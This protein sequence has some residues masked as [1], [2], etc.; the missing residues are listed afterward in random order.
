MTT[1]TIVVNWKSENGQETIAVWKEPLKLLSRSG[2][3]N[4]ENSHQNKKR[5]LKLL[6]RHGEHTNAEKEG[7]CRKSQ[8]NYIIEDPKITSMFN[9]FDSH[10]VEGTRWHTLD[11]P[12]S[13]HSGATKLLT[14]IEKTFHKCYKTSACTKARLY[15]EWITT[16]KVANSTSMLAFRRC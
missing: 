6:F 1:N 2:H 14:K 9:A 15:G 7:H 16:K 8:C 11:W 5:K 3:W 12:Q 4:C 10:Y 13:K